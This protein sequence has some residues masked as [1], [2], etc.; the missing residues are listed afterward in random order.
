MHTDT[1]T[2]DNNKL[3]EIIWN[4]VNSFCTMRTIIYSS[5]SYK[6]LHEFNL[7]FCYRAFPMRLLWVL[8]CLGLPTF[9]CILHFVRFFIPL[10]YGFALKYVYLILLNYNAYSQYFPI[11]KAKWQAIPTIY[12]WTR[13]LW[14]TVAHQFSSI[15]KI[16][17]TSWILTNRIKQL[18]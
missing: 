18:T 16:I 4:Q 5:R 13:F 7:I 3:A 9:L 12:N 2:K 14:Y 11:F 6:I 8:K 1:Y 17:K 10:T 15:V